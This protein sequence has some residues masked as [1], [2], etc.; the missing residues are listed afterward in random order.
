ME[1]RAA[2]SVGSAHK[3]SA[4]KGPGLPTLDE[5]LLTYSTIP[6]EQ[7][8][9]TLAKSMAIERVKL[10]SSAFLEVYSTKHQFPEMIQEKRYREIFEPIV[11][12]KHLL[13]NTLFFMTPMEIPMNIGV[14]H[15]TLPLKP[16]GTHNLQHLL[17]NSNSVRKIY[18]IKGN[19]KYSCLLSQSQPG[20]SGRSRTG[21]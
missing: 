10:Y 8:Q 13:S 6:F 15:E 1:L 2:E 17:E 14:T 20:V 19:D 21:F 4:F 18:I 7:N 16:K 5:L 11:F 12:Q 3:A 9:R